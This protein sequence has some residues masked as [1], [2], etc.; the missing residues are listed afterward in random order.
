MDMK[1]SIQLQR[2][3]IEN[4]KSLSEYYTELYDWEKEITK[5]DEILGVNTKS[6]Q[7]PINDK[8]ISGEKETSTNNEKQKST[9]RDKTAMQD[10]YK[11]WDQFD[12]DEDIEEKGS[13]KEMKNEIVNIKTS[14]AK[15]VNISI[16]NNRLD[17]SNE[18]YYIEKLKNEANAFFS[19]GNYNKSIELYNASLQNIEKYLN[20]ITEKNSEKVSNLLK[21]KLAIYNNKGNCLLKTGNLKEAIK[22]FDCVLSQDKNNVKALFRKGLAFY[23]LK[24]FQNALKNF[25][26]AYNLTPESEKKIINEYIDN[27][28]LEINSTINSE[29]SKMEKF[30]L[31]ETLNFKKLK[32]TNDLDFEKLDEYDSDTDIKYLL[33]NTKTINNSGKIVPNK[34]PESST[35]KTIANH[36]YVI[37]NEEIVKFVYDITKENITSSNFKFALRNLKDNKNEKIEFL[38]KVNPCY[39]T[40]IFSS[41]FDKETL[42]EIIECLI[43]LLKKR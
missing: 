20:S 25:Y 23:G 7:N 18:N 29:K 13:R 2:Q 21:T 4:S 15:S 38:K 36:A 1:S 14:N 34:K 33:Q 5:K 43:E 32:V 39:L 8:R 22:D 16:K 35:N 26:E 3:I 30:E 19:I 42:I 10:Y 37:K 11:A 12:P 9:K 27:C 24:R 17:E 28:L 31:S 40:N 41:D 6:I